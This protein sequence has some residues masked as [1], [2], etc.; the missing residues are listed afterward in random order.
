MPLQVFKWVG[1]K[2]T[3]SGGC[4]SDLKLTEVDNKLI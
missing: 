4:R 1:Q 3:L 2:V